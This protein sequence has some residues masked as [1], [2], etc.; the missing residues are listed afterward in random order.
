MCGE[1][2]AI[3]KNGSERN[4]RESGT[5]ICTVHGFSPACE[6]VNMGCGSLQWNTD[7]DETDPT[8]AERSY[9]S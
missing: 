9:S 5:Y 2:L 6:N 8:L 1:S 4:R 3:V 7:D